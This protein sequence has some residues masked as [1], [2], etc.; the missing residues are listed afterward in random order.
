MKKRNIY[1]WG[2]LSLFL[3]IVAGCNNEDARPVKP[4]KT[5]G[6]FADY[7]IKAT[8]GSETV[9]C[10]IQFHD[11]SPLGKTVLLKAPAEINFDGEPMVADSAGL[12]GIFY[13]VL[14]PLKDFEGVHSLIYQ[15][16]NGNRFEEEFRFQNI[17]VKNIPAEIS[18]EK[19]RI[20]ITGLAD[21]DYLHVVATDTSFL[22][23]DL[24]MLDTIKNGVLEISTSQLQGLVNGPVILIINHE[25][26]RKLENAPS[27]GGRLWIIHS[28]QRQFVLKN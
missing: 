20:S 25:V 21:E 6:L 3:L 1:F 28:L 9:S 22:S 12:S 4:V 24:N 13:E 5:K 8:E 18:R 27:S 11:K 7:R 23:N 15:D 17:D 19:F 26:K 10:F 2:I 14:L 16:E